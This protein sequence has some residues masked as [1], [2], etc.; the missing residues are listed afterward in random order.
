MDGFG[1]Q[2]VGKVMKIQLE[3]HRKPPVL[4]VNGIA[5]AAKSASILIQTGAAILE[6]QVNYVNVGSIF[7][8][9][10][11]NK[12]MP[13]CCDDCF[14]F[15]DRGDYPYC[16]ILHYSTGYNFSSATRRLNYCPLIEE[17][18][19]P[20]AK[21]IVRPRMD[22]TRYCDENKTMSVSTFYCPVCQTEISW[23]APNCYACG[24]V[25]NWEAL[26]DNTDDIKRFL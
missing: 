25:F 11:I 4:T 14:A 3:M 16:R 15:D 21:C 7:T 20:D 23:H 6:Y 2:R 18:P 17:E 5:A 26:Y 13:Q 10:K 8:M 12:P 22:I 9:I 1:R 19:I 24:T